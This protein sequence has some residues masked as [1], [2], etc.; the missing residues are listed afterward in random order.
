MPNTR[1]DLKTAI[2]ARLDAVCEEHEMGHQ[3]SKAAR[4]IF[5]GENGTT[6]EMMFEKNEATLANLWVKEAFVLG[7]LDGS[8]LYTRKPASDLYQKTGK[9]GAKL[10]GRHS[11][12]EKMPQIGQADL[13]CFNL[14]SAAQLDRILD[15]LDAA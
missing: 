12:M 14:T 4:Y 11:S 7:L 13:I 9:S 1:A 3:G 8:I 5:K 2:L 6:V 15:A 10:Y